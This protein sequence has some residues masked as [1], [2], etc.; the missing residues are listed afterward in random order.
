MKEAKKSKID[1][2]FFGAGQASY[3]ERLYMHIA[4]AET[5]TEANKKIILSKGFDFLTPHWEG[6]VL[7]LVSNSLAIKKINKKFNKDLETWLTKIHSNNPILV[8]YRREDLE[9]GG[10]EF[11]DWH[12]QSFEK[13]DDIVAQLSKDKKSKVIQEML[14]GIKKMSSKHQENLAA[15]Q[16]GSIE[17]ILDNE[18][19]SGLRAYLKKPSKAKLDKMAI[20]LFPSLPEKVQEQRRKVLIRVSKELFEIPNLSSYVIDQLIYMALEVSNYEVMEQII[21]FASDDV[22]PFWECITNHAAEI[23]AKP[24]LPKELKAKLQPFLH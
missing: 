20:A 23:A 17:D 9:A 3:F 1:F 18:D 13:F 15:L 16:S 19:E 7:V 11:S 8:V 2:P 6:K 10:T 5:L 4:F 14:V 22:N 21:K 24:K 12:S